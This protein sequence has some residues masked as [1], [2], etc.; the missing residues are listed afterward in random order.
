VEGLNSMPGRRS[1]LL[2]MRIAGRYLPLNP[3]LAG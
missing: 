2:L 3:R 1:K